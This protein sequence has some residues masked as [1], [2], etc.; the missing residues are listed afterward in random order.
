MRAGR[1]RT[2]THMIAPHHELNDASH[3]FYA[4]K[5]QHSNNNNNNNLFFVFSHR[6]NEFL[7]S[8]FFLSR[9]DVYLLDFIFRVVFGRDSQLLY[10][11]L[12]VRAS[13]T[14]GEGLVCLCRARARA[15]L[16]RAHTGFKATIVSQ[17][18][19]FALAVVRAQRPQL[20]LVLFR[21]SSFAAD[22]LAFLF[23]SRLAWPCVRAPNISAGS[24]RRRRHRRRGCC[25]F[26]HIISGAHVRFVCM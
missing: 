26:S 15:R 25:V 7:F 10:S 3:E 8:S 4:N 1:M 19:H 18:S 6:N 13:C 20:L 5:K 2:T 14:L 21:S 11:R 22:R 16:Y 9:S 24:R 12:C 23:H 17:P